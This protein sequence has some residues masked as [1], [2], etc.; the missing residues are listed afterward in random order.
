MREQPR[1]SLSAQL[2]RRSLLRGDALQTVLER[3]DLV[4]Q[5]TD[6]FATNLEPPFDLDLAGL[7]ATDQFLP[8]VR[9][10]R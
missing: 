10:L 5:I 7:Q 4:S 1:L 9:E 2:G 8:V 3:H 6:H